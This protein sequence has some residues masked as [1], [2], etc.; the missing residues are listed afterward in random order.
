MKKTTGTMFCWMAV[1]C[2]SLVLFT[3]CESRGSRLFHTGKC[4]ECHTISG[5]GGSSGPN[6]TDVGSRRSR[7][8]I[9][10]Q[11]RNPRSHKPD[12]DMPSFEGRLPE[13]D[14]EDLADYLSGL[15]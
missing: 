9:I 8:Y 13:K 4:I 1:P 12:T 3:A 6:L 7:D 11:I 14:I 2:L 15:K 5:E 10:Q